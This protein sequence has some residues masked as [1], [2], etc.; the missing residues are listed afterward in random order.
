[1]EQKRLRISTSLF[2]RCRKAF[3]RDSLES[4]ADDRGFV[5]AFLEASGSFAVVETKR[6]GLNT[7]THRNALKTF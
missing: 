5:T 4:L 6:P 2:R 1:M 3:D 7:V